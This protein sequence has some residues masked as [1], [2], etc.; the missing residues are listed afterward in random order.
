MQGRCAQGTNLSRHSLSGWCKWVSFLKASGQP[1]ACCALLNTAHPRCLAYF[2]PALSSNCQLIMLCW[3]HK[4]LTVLCLLLSP[5][6]S[7]LL[8]P[9]VCPVNIYVSICLSRLLQSFL[10]NARYS[11][12]YIP[13]DLAW[14]HVCLTIFKFQNL[15]GK[16]WCYICVLSILAQDLYLSGLQ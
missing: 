10:L 9:P 6:W 11:H 16:G 13:Q 8:D 14:T 12:L 7:C 2:T 1:W 5:E 4:T 3:A 15:W